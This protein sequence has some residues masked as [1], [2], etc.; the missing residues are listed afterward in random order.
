MMQLD[1]GTSDRARMFSLTHSINAGH[2][3]KGSNEDTSPKILLHTTTEVSVIPTGHKF[4]VSPY[5]YDYEYLRLGT[6]IF[7]D[8]HVLYLYLWT[9]SKD[10]ITGISP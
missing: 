3:S 9:F 2:I 1:N 5:F 8:S 4:D 10:C 6:F 7:C